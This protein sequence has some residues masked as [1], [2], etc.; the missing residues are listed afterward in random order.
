MRAPAWAAAL[1]LLLPAASV[2][3]P[4][5]RSDDACGLKLKIVRL[6]D[7]ALVHSFS[8]DARGAVWIDGCPKAR[9]RGR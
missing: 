5:F 1:V 6:K 4:S 7:G 3:K 2:A 9:G 8:P